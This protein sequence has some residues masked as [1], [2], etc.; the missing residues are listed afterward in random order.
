MAHFVAQDNVQDGRCFGVAMMAQ[1]VAHARRDIQTARFED[2]RHQRHAREHIFLGLLRHP[3]Q[4]AVRGEVAVVVAVVLLEML[5]QQ[6]EVIRLF[7]GNRDPIKIVV[8]WHTSEAAHR[9][10]RQVDGVEF[11]VSDG[12]NHR[13]AALARPRTALRHARRMQQ[14]GP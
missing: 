12:V 8:T 5:R 1:L 9:V 6:R 13:C 7:F 3:P 14:L 10:E 4:A 2:A 11:D